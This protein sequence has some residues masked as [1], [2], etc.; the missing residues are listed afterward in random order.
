MAKMLEV[1]LLLLFLSLLKVY[2]K[3]PNSGD[4]PSV[5]SQRAL[6]PLPSYLGPVKYIQ[7]STYRE[8]RPCI[9]SL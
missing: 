3:R 9:V 2:G 1:H 8:I 6:I 7:T 5:M 4:L